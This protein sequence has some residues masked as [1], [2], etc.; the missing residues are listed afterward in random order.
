MQNMR[1]RAL[2]IISSVLLTHLCCAQEETTPVALLEETVATSSEAA[3]AQQP[4]QEV[5]VTAAPMQPIEPMVPT[6]ETPPV[7]TNEPAASSEQDEIEIKGID[8][9]DIAQPKGNWLYKRIWWEKAERLYE[10]IKQLAHQISE[11][12]IVF[13]LKRHDLD[14]TVID[15]FYI[16]MGIDQGGLQEITAYLTAQLE[17]ER[18]AGQLDE[19]EQKLL[20]TIAQEKKTL[21]QMSQGSQRVDKLMSALED[22]LIKLLEQV[23]QARNYEQLSWD[24]FKAINRELSDKRARELYYN[25]DTYW[26]NLNNINTY[27]T[28]SYTKYFEQLTAKVK[29]EVDS[30]QGTIQGLKEKGVDIKMQAQKLRMGC[31]IPSAEQETQEPEE[32]TGILAR[33]WG[34]IK[35]PF[36]F[37][38]DTFS[39]LFG[40]GAEEVTLLRRPV[41]ATQESID[42]EAEVEEDQQ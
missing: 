27:L 39:G 24:A 42:I 12:R 16:S 6:I 14:R 22:A 11:S 20:D 32:S 30:I 13:F 1:M 23:N 38:A 34:W 26:K 4:M 25:M 37:I 41:K 35:A 5:P 9:V 10:K 29:E 17:Q 3:T 36:A 15:P 19:Q 40:G 21:E 8:T 31:K 2:S 28:D 18:T 7:V 33:I